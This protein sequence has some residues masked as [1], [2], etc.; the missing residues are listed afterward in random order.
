M[1]GTGTSRC[2]VRAAVSGCCIGPQEAV[3]AMRAGEQGDILHNLTP[4]N[5]TDPVLGYHAKCSLYS[6]VFKV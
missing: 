6:D 5:T 1:P 4:A 2:G 3:M